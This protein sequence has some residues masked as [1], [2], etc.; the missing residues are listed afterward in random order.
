MEAFWVLI[1]LTCQGKICKADLDYETFPNKK[2]C[3]LKRDRIHLTQLNFGK[4]IRPTCLPSWSALNVP[5]E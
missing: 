4:R 1:L 3:E 2:V 5:Q